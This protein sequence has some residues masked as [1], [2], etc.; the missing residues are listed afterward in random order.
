MIENCDVQPRR[1]EVAKM[2]KEEE[3]CLLRSGR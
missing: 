2:R 1:R 3:K